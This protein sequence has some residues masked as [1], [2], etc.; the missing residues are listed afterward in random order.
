MTTYNGYESWDHWN[1]ALWINND[2]KYYRDLLEMIGLAKKLGMSALS[3]ADV[4]ITKYGDGK[5]P[6]GAE[7]QFQTVHDLALE[8]W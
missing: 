1:T 8:N 7:W 3:V 4:W 6:D 2:E 5:T